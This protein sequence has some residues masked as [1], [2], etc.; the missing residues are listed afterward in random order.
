MIRPVF[1]YCRV[2][3]KSQIDGHGL[4]RQM[5]SIKEFSTT[6]G[7]KLE[8]VFEEQV[9]G[10]KDEDERPEFARMITEILLDG[11]NT[12]VVESLDSRTTFQGIADKLNAEGIITRQGKS[13]DP[14]LMYNVTK[15]KKGRERSNIDNFRDSRER[16]KISYL[17]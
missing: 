16:S 1:A 13:W 15:G 5:D 12:I 2:S 10:T 6:N 9:S 4:E 14:A 8:K 3:G 7:Y 17:I 11:T